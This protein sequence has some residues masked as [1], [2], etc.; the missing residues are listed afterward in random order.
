MG[1][2]TLCTILLSL[3]YPLHAAAM[4]PCAH[5]V[6]QRGGAEEALT[7]SKDTSYVFE[8]ARHGG[9]GVQF[10]KVVCGASVWRGPIC[11]DSLDTLTGGPLQPVLYSVTMSI[12]TLMLQILCSQAT[13][14]PCCT[15]PL[16]WISGKAITC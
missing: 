15:C 8:V 12:V 9:G 10:C 14:A 5:P 1:S 11:A 16:A 4:P 3:C 6:I 2:T 13:P 7:H